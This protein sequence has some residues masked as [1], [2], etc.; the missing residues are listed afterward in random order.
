M[1]VYAAM[2]DCVD[3]NLGRLFAY[4]KSN[5]Q[6]DDT[7]VIFCSDN[8][9]SDEH[10]AAGD[11]PPGPLDGWHAYGEDWAN[12]S[13]TPFR[14]H[15]KTEWYGGN[16][17]PAIAHWPGQVPAGARSDELAHLMDFM[18]TFLELADAP[19]PGGHVD[20]CD[21]ISLLPVLRGGSRNGYEALCWEF[22]SA[23]AIISGDWKLVTQG[24]RPWELYDIRNDR[25]ELHDLAATHPQVVAELDARW[26]AW[27]QEMG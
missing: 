10:K 7:L 24:K 14:K 4:L 25:C 19:Y 6:W 16:L 2:L 5:G 26:R 18:P 21:G 13:N 22:R 9:G 1:A 20:R 3:Q 8:G 11:A 15:K 27:K 12:V 17:T 23:R